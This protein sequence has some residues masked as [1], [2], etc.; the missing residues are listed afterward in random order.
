[1]TAI[2]MCYSERVVGE[3]ASAELRLFIGSRRASARA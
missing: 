1:L 3:K 2:G